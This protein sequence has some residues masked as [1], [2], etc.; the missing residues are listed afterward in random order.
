MK[1]IFM[2]VLAVIL[3]F[4]LTGCTDAD[5]VGYNVSKDADQFKVKR[6]ITFINLRTDTYMFSITGLCSINVDTDNDL[7][8]ICKVGEDKYQKHFLH[9]ANETTYVVE[10][11]EYTE[12]SKYKYEIVFKPESIIPITIDVE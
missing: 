8:V 7:N 3:I 4:S 5:M 2:V 1:K 12:T 11:L 9:L 6:R 10:Q